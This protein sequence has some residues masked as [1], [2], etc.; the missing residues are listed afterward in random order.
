MIGNEAYPVKE[1]PQTP[2][3]QLGSTLLEPTILENID[4]KIAFYKAQIKRLEETREKFPK[5]LGEMKISD[6]REVM[7]Y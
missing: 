5:S 6:L 4:R 2:T 3:L 7:N 1:G